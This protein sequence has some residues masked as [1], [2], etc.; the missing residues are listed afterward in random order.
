MSYMEWE[1]KYAVGVPGLDTE[2]KIMLDLISQL[3]DGYAADKGHDF[4]EG[5]FATLSDYTDTHFRHEEALMERI[6]FPGTD[7]HKTHHQNMKKEMNDLHGR[8][9]AGDVEVAKDLLAFLNN[10][11]HFHI[12]EADG[13]Y[14]AFM[15]EKGIDVSPVHARND[16]HPAFSRVARS[17]PLPGVDAF[18]SRHVAIPVGW[19]LTEGSLARVVDAV[20][21]WS[22]T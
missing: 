3:H 20:T 7:G 21:A 5:I 1:D 11:W 19:W 22:R 10:W 4:L 8:F 12:I 17:G 6:G 13:A 9:E 15:K 14:A 2:H 16:I 18:S